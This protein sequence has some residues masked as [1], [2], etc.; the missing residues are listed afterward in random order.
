MAQLGESWVLD[1]ALGPRVSQA[2]LER[3]MRF[4]ATHQPGVPVR[5]ENETDGEY[6]HRVYRYICKEKR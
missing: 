6:R 2:D 3:L 5:M 4:M 1:L